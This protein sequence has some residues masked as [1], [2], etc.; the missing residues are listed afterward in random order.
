MHQERLITLENLERFKGNLESS[1]G[2][3]E[4]PA[5]LDVNGNIAANQIPE[6]AYNIEE[7]QNRQ[8]FPAEGKNKRIYVDLSTNDFY[9]WDNVSNEYVSAS[10][11]DGVKYTQQELTD[12]Q[13]TQARN[14]IGAISAADVPPGNNVQYIQQELTAEQQAQARQNINA[15]SPDEIPAGNN[16]QYIQQELTSEQKAQARQNISAISSEDLP[17]DNN[18]KY[19]QQELTTE[20]K[21]QARQNI[22]AISANDLPVDNNVKYVSQELTTEQQT[23]ARQNINAVSPD[24]VPPGDNVR[25]VS[26]EL[27]SEQK[28]QARQNIDAVAPDEVPAGENV[29]YVSQTL[30]TAQKTQARQNID[31]VSPDEVPP[32]ENVRYVSQELTGEQK[33]QARTNIGAASQTSVNDLGD[34]VSDLNDRLNNF[35]NFVRE[36]EEI[37]G[38]IRVKYDNNSTDDIATGLVFDGGIV[39]ENNDLY[40]KLGEEILPNDV[41]T[42]IHLP[43]GGGGGGG[44]G[45]SMS[46]V[47]KPKS[48]RN[49]ADAIFSFVC[50]T[51]DDTGVSVKW[52]VNDVLITSTNGD[53][54]DTFSF[55]ARDYLT[56]SDTSVV[57]VVVDSEG[58]SSLT[59]KWSIT[60]V[61]FAISWGTS[62]EPVMFNNTNT[63]VFAPINV[64]AEANM[65]NIV[66]VTVGTNRITRNVT[67][68]L[69]LNVQL[70][71]TFFQAGVNTVVA[72]MANAE[73]P[74]DKADD[75]QFKVVWG[76]GATTP[77]VVF[78]EDSIECTQYDVVNIK[79][80]VFEPNDE[81]AQYTIQ[82]GEEEPR[83]MTA[84]RTLQT[85]QYTP[86]EEVTTTVTLTCGV[87]TTS[88]P[89]H[90]ARSD[91]NLSYYTDDSLLYVLN[92]VGHSNSDADRE[93]FG[94]LVFSEDFDWENGGFRADNQGAAAFVIKKGNTVTLPRCLF[95]DSDTNGKTIDISFKITNSDSYD[96]VAMRELNDGGTKG[97]VLKANNGELRLNNVVGQEFRYCEDSRVDFSVL[98]ESNVAQRVATVWLDGIP[99][100]VNKYTAPNTLVQNE[101]KLVIGSEHCDVW[102]YAIR[103]YNSQLTKKQ[104]I[105]N[106][107]SCGPTTSEKV[108]RYLLNNILDSNDRI[109]VAQLHT[110]APNLTIVQLAA[111]RMTVS[112]EDPVP[113][114]ITITDGA[115]VLELPAED[116][117]VFKVQGTSSA[118][119]GRSA[120]NLDIDFKNTGKKYKISENAIAV[121][122]INIKVNVASS[123][124]AN[125]INAVDWYNTYQPYLTV[126][127]QTPGVRDTVEGKPCAVFIT[128]TSDEPKWFS[129]LYVRPGE[130]I[131]YAM[132]DI[133]NSKKNKAVFGQDGKGDNHTKACIEVSGNDT[134]PQRFRSTAAVFNPA[135][136]DGKG[137]W[138]T[139]EWDE[140]EQK[141]K[142]VKHFEWRMNP[143]SEDQEEVVNSWNALVAWVVSTIG[144]S[145]KFKR[146]AGNYFAMTSMLYHFLFIEYFAGYDNVSKNTFYSYDWDEDAQ[147]YLW[148]IKAAY[149]MDTILAADN[150]GKPFGDY[151][152]DYGDTVDGT[153][154]GRQYFNAADNPIWVNIQEAFKDELSALYISLRSNGAWN[155]QNIENKWNRY[156]DIRPHAS[157]IVD[158]Y[159]KYIE[160]YKTTD[161]VIGTETKSYDDSYLPRLQ[162]SKI[163]WRKQFLTY[164][165]NYMD[166]KY[167][168]YST[169]DSIMFRTNCEAGTRTFSVKAYA[170]TY[171]TAIVDSNKAGSRKINAGDVITFNN[172]SV[173]TNTTLYFTPERLIQYI[174]PLNDTKI[175]TYT[176]PGAAKL[177]EAIIGGEEVNSSWPAGTGVS[178]PSVVLKDLSI[179]NLPNFSDSLDA[180]AN[181]ELETIDTRGTSAGLITLPSFAP[182]ASVQLN[183]CTGIVAYNLNKVE[184]FTMES[185]LNLVS[186]QIENCNTVV[187]N[188]VKTY[189]VQAMSSTQTA[190]RRIRAID[191][192]WEFDNLDTLSKIATTWKGYNNLGEEQDKPVVTGTMHVI[193]LSKKKLEMIN[194]VWGE[195]TVDDHLDEDHRVWEYGNLR[196]TYESLIPYFTITFLNSDDTHIKDKKG[197]NYYQYVDY[198]G[199]A[200]EPISAGD[201]NTPTLIDPEGQY[202]YTFD[203]WTNLEGVVVS[204]KTV[205]ATYTSEVITYTVRWFDRSGGVE[206][207][208]RENVAYGSEAVY[209]VE[210]KGLPVL[211]N[212]EI[213]GVYKVFTGWDKSTGFITGDIDV[214]ATWETAP[215]PS[216]TKKLKNMNIAEIYGIS[217]TNRA[218]EYFHDEDYVDIKVGKDFTFSNVESAV[219]M[220]NRYFNGSEIVRMNDIKLFDENAPSFTLAIDYEY[221]RVRADDTI[222]SCC[223]PD[224]NTEGFRVFITDE[225]R[226]QND[227]PS[228]NG[229]CVTVL[230]GDRQEVVAH[231]MNRGIIV[232][233]H[234][235]GSKNLYIASDNNGRYITHATGDGGDE[236]M[237]GQW[238]TYRHDAYNDT[239]LATEIPRTR[240]TVIDS[241]LTFGGVATG[242]EGSKFEAKG[243]IHWCKIWYADLGAT[244]IQQLASWPHETWRMQYRGSGIY[245]KADVSGNKDSASFIAN[246]PLPLYYEVYNPVY[247]TTNEGGWK[248]SKLRSFINGRC[249]NALPYEWQ[250]IIKP[251][252]IPTKGGSDNARNIEYSV[253]K[254]YIP[255]YVDMKEPNEGDLN[256]YLLSE[257]SRISWFTQNSAR[258][259]FMGI[260]IPLA[261]DGGQVITTLSDDPTL[262]TDTYT[263][264][265]GDIWIPTSSS[266]Y[267]YAY[268]Y[269][270]AT[271]AAKHGYY[272]GRY[273][274]DTANNINAAGAQG[275][276]WIKSRTY[277]TR[278]N[279]A[280][281]PTQNQNYQF[282]VYPTGNT[283]TVYI[284]YPEY[285]RRGVVLMFSI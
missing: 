240:E 19:V 151:G 158:A 95:E 249:Y 76:T 18:V 115:T 152:I 63:N 11:P 81:T 5:I 7:Y 221:A 51:S 78:A 242:T 260:N 39:D 10:S 134:E 160:P 90:A 157:M 32:G 12:E 120:Y 79:Y 272:G 60:S 28:A 175:S 47:V 22:N 149:D 209:D 66:T 99:A 204:D 131:L 61:A 31:A 113:A 246:A 179:R 146:E 83:S 237:Y 208:K 154:S 227:W 67:G 186:V 9:R 275:G 48:V 109:S 72:S 62:I 220:E 104:M 256:T 102:I 269:I 94:N 182:L 254:L 121:N 50:T 128:N 16:V 162:G 165:T 148:N 280:L 184:T 150:D 250:A 253:D 37:E 27:T 207:D 114:D 191:V 85:Y 69:T 262:Y 1:Y 77:I 203:G 183:A 89:F 56:P 65:N 119:Y 125:N 25:Y 213:A 259:K 2:K 133:C 40:L 41:F 211:D 29:R 205:K 140:S 265:E 57:K 161:V 68:S 238:Q 177:T 215:I 55:N 261:S 145:A 30:T 224:G 172:I 59:R 252:R 195:G 212:Q 80:F 226:G 75:I 164:Q 267:R 163:Y 155:S 200:Y 141:Y 107:V 281:S 236:L 282:S 147:K 278:T 218:A 185:G 171:V 248:N 273:I 270:S 8:A 258:V 35:G 219:L 20:Q 13:K 42:P 181:V 45:I 210:N 54:G 116:G 103:V 142:K 88:I 130:T 110:A 244:A 93:L 84:T 199:T 235:K 97:I 232:L 266:S 144:D 74:T 71:K 222:I 64:S 268:V 101:N 241:T 136:D 82:V 271:T 277:W 216:T 4:G 14:N 87:S 137:R 243:W 176:A 98:V 108:N 23:L 126:S 92:P 190:T 129:S 111:N 127:R 52:Y 189:L 264:N 180:S 206:L 188:A 274:N 86:L 46:D 33:T 96:T 229:E 34:A 245:N 36:V 156:Q 166:G 173:G 6:D 49:G 263:I 257:G 285:T 202:R 223:D 53:S 73:D 201:I 43:E 197:N 24:E 251:V 217:K 153:P 138:E 193:T 167:G 198:L 170:K 233:R 168:Y 196:I 117:T 192:S 58:G 284:S 279:R 106:Y 283:G 178:I 132:G 194:N 3:P 26:Q 123:E 44:S 234:R 100:N 91:Y 169:S 70:D 247:D 139:E 124:N 225:G 214:Y 174:R 122:Y 159:N 230:W 231:G 255:A 105:Q 276:V 118:A 21:T 135:A 112:K 38:G 187:S 143:A 15:V 228:E 17:V 239:I